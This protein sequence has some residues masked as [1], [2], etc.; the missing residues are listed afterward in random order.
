MGFSITLKLQA[1]IEEELID[2][3]GIRPQTFWHPR[4]Q[5]SHEERKDAASNNHIR[6][7]VVRYMSQDANTKILSRQ[8]EGTYTQTTETRVSQVQ[9]KEKC[10]G[11][12]SHTSPVCAPLPCQ[13]FSFSPLLLELEPHHANQQDTK[14]SNE[15]EQDQY[16]PIVTAGVESKELVASKFVTTNDVECECR[17]RTNSMINSAEILI[18]TPWS[19]STIISPEPT[20]FT[21][22]ASRVN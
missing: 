21:E 10:H 2:L 7:W 8:N 4:F 15:R 9:A 17:T 16:I 13:L 1:G 3:S 12:A 18:G 20:S 6:T 14:S 11:S 22:S 19:S 5:S